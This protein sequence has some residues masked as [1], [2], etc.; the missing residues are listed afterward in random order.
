MRCTIE[1]QGNA[2]MIRAGEQL[3]PPYAYMTYQPAKGRSA[4]FR[5][6]GVRFVSVAVYA[7]DRGINPSSGIRP[8]RPGFMTAPG[9]Y[10]F[11]WADEDFRRATCGKAPGEAFILPRLM[12]EMPVWWEARHPEALCRDAAGA[13]AFFE[14]LFGTAKG[15]GEFSRCDPL[16]LVSP[17][18]PPV[19]LLLSAD[20]PA[21]TVNQSETFH[22]A[23]RRAIGEQ[24]ALHSLPAGQ[25]GWFTAVGEIYAFLARYLP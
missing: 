7:G 14:K 15:D 4:D 21:E 10:D 24:C 8:F 5:E 22:Q 11:S 20:A 9:K 23:L 25:R 19:F 12:L 3:L 1:R 16:H 18:A 17:D 6:A 13:Q 2:F